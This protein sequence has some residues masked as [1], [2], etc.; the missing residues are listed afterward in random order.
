[1]SAYGQHFHIENSDDG[2]MTQDYGVE[3]EF[4]QCSRASH[5]D[6]NLVRGTLGYVGKI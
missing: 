4:D 1:M 6:Q 3:V 2:H 5:H